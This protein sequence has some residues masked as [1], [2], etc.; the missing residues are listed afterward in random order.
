MAEKI[1]ELINFLANLF[2]QKFT[3]LTNAIRKMQEDVSASIGQNLM[4]FSDLIVG[5]VDNLLDLV[6][7]IRQDIQEIKKE[8][9]FE[10][11]QEAELSELIRQTVSEESATEATKPSTA[12]TPA[13]TVQKTPPIVSTPA[14]TVQ[15]TPP[16]VS[17]PAP[18]VQKTPPIV[19]KPAPTVQKTPPIVSKPAP[20]V[21]KP[22][23]VKPTVQEPSTEPSEIIPEEVPQLFD[24]IS[25]AVVS[26]VSARELASIMDNARN[27]IIKVFRWHPVLYELA[28]FSRRIQKLPGDS[29]ISADISSLLIEKIQDWKKRISGD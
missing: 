5:K 10:M 27:Q 8:K 9:E 23:I 29:P 21:Q 25:N 4:Q 12:S 19:S 24:G 18:T 28:S 15:K 16:I 13:P 1:D 11:A 17:K 3:E 26:N 20:T 14:P 7:E 2:D 6:N 22:P